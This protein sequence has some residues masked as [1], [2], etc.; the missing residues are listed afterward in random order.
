MRPPYTCIYREIWD[1]PKFWEMSEVGRLVCF[2][3]MTAPLGTGLGCFKAGKAAMIEEARLPAERFTE[4]FTEGLAKGLFEYNEKYRVIL[5]PKYFARNAPSNPNGITAMSKEYVKIPDCDLKIKC[6]HIVRTFVETKGEGFKERFK[7]LFSEPLRQPIEQPPGTISLS[8][9]PPLPLSPSKAPPSITAAAKS[10]STDIPKSAD[11]WNSYSEAYRD[12]YGTFP[13][14]DD[15]KNKEIWPYGKPAQMNAVHCCKLVDKLGAEI[16]PHV[17][18]FYVSSSD[19][20]YVR[21]THQLNLL[22]QNADSFHT[23]WKTG[24]QMTT[25]KAREVDRI[26]K[27]RAGW[28]GLIDKAEGEERGTQ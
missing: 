12:R 19:Q 13:P 6:F 21:N 15:V 26:E 27:T 23:Q 10:S 24:N 17:A 2:Y 3:V 28:Q 25:T 9:S 14:H 20:F 22:V 18:A 16:A 5:I 11:T 7:E 8:L 1:D 4:G